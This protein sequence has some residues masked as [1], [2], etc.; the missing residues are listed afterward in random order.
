MRSL[1]RSLTFEFKSFDKS[2][3]QNEFKFEFDLKLVKKAYEMFVKCLDRTS[4]ELYLG[5]DE[6]M[7]GFEL[8]LADD[9]GNIFK[10]KFNFSFFV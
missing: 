5:V 3:D 7:Q 6:N 8:I 10:K 4:Y 9:L 1:A 2:L